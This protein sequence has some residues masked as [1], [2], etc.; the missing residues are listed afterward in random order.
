MVRTQIQLTESQVLFLKNLATQRQQSL[1]ELIRQS[2]D[3]F[4]QR[5]QKQ[6]DDWEIKKQRAL[7]AIG[8]FKADVPDLSENHDYYFVEAVLDYPRLPSKPDGSQ[9]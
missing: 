9:A 7:S 2:V 3:Q 1:A 6:G 4:I 5:Q 8:K